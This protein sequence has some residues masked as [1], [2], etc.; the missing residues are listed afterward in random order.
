MP[1]GGLC[2]R[3]RAMLAHPGKE[4]AGLA[5]RTSFL[6]ALAVA[7]LLGLAPVVSHSLLTPDETTGAG[8][9]GAMAGG[10]D[11]IVP[12]LNAKPFIEKPP[13]YWWTLAGSLRL[14]GMSDVAARFPSA[15]FAVLTLLVAWEAG[16]RLGGPRQG[17][18]ATAVL[19]STM[20]FVQNATR[21]TV[22]PALMFFVA[23]AHL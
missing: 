18:L 12:R 19:G 8:I 15:L 9:G 2:Y 14:L 11:G 22:D 21:V 1:P 7:L 5:A 6:L 23:L 17:V 10:G 16:R 13:L 3:L 4:D 20:L